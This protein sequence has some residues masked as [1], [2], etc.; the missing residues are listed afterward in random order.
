MPYIFKILIF[1]LFLLFSFVRCNDSESNR[2]STN[3]SNKSDTLIQTDKNRSENNQDD[4][5][6][7]E[8]DSYHNQEVIATYQ[9][10]SIYA[11]ATHYYFETEEGQEILVAKRMDEETPVRLP[12]NMLE[13]F[14]LGESPPDANPAFIGNIFTLYFN[15][16]GLVY[17]V[18]PIK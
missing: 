11:T 9:S 3:T 16:K 7:F 12:D 13:E 14:E 15:E 2:N 8:L 4:E 5:G 6:I 1:S 17:K 10:A 18:I